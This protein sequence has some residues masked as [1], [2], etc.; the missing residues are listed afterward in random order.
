MERNRA[1]VRLLARAQRKS[2]EPSLRRAKACCCW[3]KNARKGLAR[4]LLLSFS[5]FFFIMIIFYPYFLLL[6]YSLIDPSFAV[7]HLF[8]EEKKTKSFPAAQRRNRAA[9]N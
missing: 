8:L 5:V 9:K 4:L 7:L 2:L 6:T 3:A 1:A